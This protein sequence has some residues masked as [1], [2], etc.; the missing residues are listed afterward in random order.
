MPADAKPFKGTHSI[1][2]LIN[3]IDLLGTFLLIP[4][5]ICLLLALQWGG[6]EHA[7]NS[8]R[9]ILLLVL[10][11]VLFLVWV[12]VQF[13][14]GEKATLPIR[15]VRQRSLAAGILYTVCTFGTFFVII[16]YVNIWFQAV[17][18]VSAYHSG[19]NF[20]STSVAMAIS[21]ICSGF[22]TTRIGYYVPNMI[23]ST[24]FASVGAGLIYTFDRSTSTSYW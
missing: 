19:I 1:K 18:G 10:F 13:K 12:F 16:Y 17:R 24:V 14:Q 6:T 21:V 22:I 15:L 8:W 4:W 7:W 11:A 23:A 2:E 9:I 3:K 20:L 5:V